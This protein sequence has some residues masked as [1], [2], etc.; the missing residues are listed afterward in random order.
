MNDAAM[1]QSVPTAQD[2][3]SALRGSPAVIWAQDAALRYVWVFNP[4]MGRTA[5]EIVG[6]T[7]HELLD[8]ASADMLDQIK[9]KAM[10]GGEEQNRTVKI[11]AGDDDEIFE[12]FI[13]PI[14]GAD[15]SALGV[16][17]VAMRV[18]DEGRVLAVEADHRIKNSLALAQALLRTQSRGT[19]ET[20]AREALG[21]AASEIGAIANL[22]G[23]LAEGGSDGTVNLREYLDVAFGELA[24][25]FDDRKNVWIETDVAD[26]IIDGGVALKLAL[27]ATEL[28]TNSVKH[29]GKDRPSL[30]IRVT[31]ARTED[32]PRMTV[33]DDGDGLRYDFDAR[34]DTGIGM[35][36]I[37][38]LAE[39][40]GTSPEIDRRAHGA[41]FV[42]TFADM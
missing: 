17:G 15:G 22:H 40:L 12:L 9:R 24:Q 20:G 21:R 25:I 33:E 6:K 7:D 8:K 4:T 38:T 35:R 32:G 11:T 19:S 37:Q 2:L 23:K 26:E 27:I 39:A 5:D 31:Y 36:V 42:F 1:N 10:A 3:R 30:F 16:T 29:A 18:S 41:R 28:I 13:R 34:G 14:V